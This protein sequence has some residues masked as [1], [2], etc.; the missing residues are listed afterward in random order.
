MGLKKEGGTGGG[1]FGWHGCKEAS[2]VE[3]GEDGGERTARE[4]RSKKGGAHRRWR[5]IQLQSSSR[6]VLPSTLVC[7]A[8]FAYFSFERV[9]GSSM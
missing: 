4:S 7:F 9:L 8:F 6:F 3:G 2:W 5:Q 1:S